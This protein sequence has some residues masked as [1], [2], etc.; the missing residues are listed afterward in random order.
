MEGESPTIK[1]TN[2]MVETKGSI[3][4]IGV[5]AAYRPGIIG[6]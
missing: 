5:G 6:T 3:H 4:S 2:Y 1:K